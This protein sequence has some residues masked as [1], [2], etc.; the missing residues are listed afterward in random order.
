MS[1][2]PRPAWIVMRSLLVFSLVPLLG[3][4]TASGMGMQAGLLAA[5]VNPMEWFYGVDTQEVAFGE[6]CTSLEESYSGTSSMSIGVRVDSVHASATDSLAEGQDLEATVTFV[7][8]GNQTARYPRSFLTWFF[9][10]DEADHRIQARAA[11]MQRASQGPTRL[12]PA[13][14]ESHTVFFPVDSPVD[15]LVMA[16]PHQEAGESDFCRFERPALE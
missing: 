2:L 7:N 12:D 15:R 16:I 13:G 10:V 11:P 9:A 14:S 8:V 3:G 5:G 6:V 1:H 4:C